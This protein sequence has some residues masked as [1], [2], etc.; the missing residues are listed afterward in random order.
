MDN[1]LT[2]TYLRSSANKSADLSENYIEEID[3]RSIHL[4]KPL[5]KLQACHSDPDIGR[6]KNLHGSFAAVEREI[7]HYVQDDCL[8]CKNLL[9]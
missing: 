5:Q 3:F 2:D 7:L 9:Q 1:L 6:E 8:F 4:Q